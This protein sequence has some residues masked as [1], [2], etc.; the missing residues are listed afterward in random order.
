MRLETTRL[1]IRSYEPRDAVGMLR[2]FGDPEVRKYLP[3][4]PDPTLERMQASV[5]RRIAVER[6]RDDPL[7]SEG[8]ESPR[9]ARDRGLRSEALVPGAAPVVVRDLDLRAGPIDEHEAALADEL[10]R[11][12]ALDGPQRMAMVPLH[13]HAALDAGLHPLERRRR[14]RRQVLA[15]LGIAQ[16]LEHRGRAGDDPAAGDDGDP[17][18]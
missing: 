1:V 7:E 14:I 11:V 10:A 9:E 15:H 2:V 3:P 17:Q 12:L 6:E 16:D 8:S 4:S 13:G 18:L 5:E